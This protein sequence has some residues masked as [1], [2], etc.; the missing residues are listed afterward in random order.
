MHAGRRAIVAQ[1]AGHAERGGGDH[2]GGHVRQREIDGGQGT[3][4]GERDGAAGQVPRAGDRLAAAVLV[5]GAAR[6]QQVV[7][8]GRVGARAQRQRQRRQH[9]GH[10]ERGDPVGPVRDE[11]RGDHQRHRAGHHR[12][13]AADAIGQHAGRD[14]DDDRDHAV[15]APEQQPLEERQPTLL[16]EQHEDRDVQVRRRQQAEQVEQ[17]QV[18]R[19]ELVPR[20]SGVD[21][22]P[23]PRRPAREAQR[24]GLLVGTRRV[25]TKRPGMHRRRDAVN[26]G[27]SGH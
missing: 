23:V 27:W 17:A 25:A 11:R 14:L 8:V 2:G 16:L 3:A 1:Q 9:L 20:P 10:G 19:H 18:A 21:C 12:A 6:R 15:Q 5:R 26:T 22:S 13:P 24:G 4:A 7:E